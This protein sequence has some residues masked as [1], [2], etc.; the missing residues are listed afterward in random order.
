MYQ[1]KKLINLSLAA[2][3]KAQYF[4]L[5]CQNITNTPK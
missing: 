2:L 3:Q 1:F 4:I 5:F